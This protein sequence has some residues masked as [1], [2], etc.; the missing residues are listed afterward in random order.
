MTGQGEAVRSALKTEA[1]RRSLSTDLLVS[2][3]LAERFLHRLYLSAHAGRLTL[4][5][6]FLFA[7]WEGDLL[8]ST[9]DVDLHAAEGDFGQAARLV[10]EVAAVVP[11][12]DD[13]VRFEHGGAE[14]R[15]LSPGPQAVTRVTMSAGVGP[16][17]GRLKV[18]V[19]LGGGIRP[20][21]EIRQYP[22]LL[23]GFPSFPVRT[24]PREA[25]VAEKLAIAVEFGRDNTRLRDYWDLWFITNR[26]RFSGHVL[27][28]AA[29][30][31]FSRRDAGR[32]VT[33]RDGYWESAFDRS[34][35]AS[36]PPGAWEA[37]LRMHA[38]VS[39]PSLEEAVQSVARFSV[40]L[41]QAI[42]DGSRFDGRWSAK[43]GWQRS[44]HQNVT[45]D[46]LAESPFHAMP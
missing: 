2:R 20:G 36:R 14:A 30:S 18:D 41:L 5:G 32:F 16:A 43:H 6:A 42:R 31:A 44:P 45:E 40:P 8:R 33:R 22:S 15:I 28:D 13:G 4:K 38:P 29:A 10:A 19:G 7:A 46:P 35:A 1:R 34:F 9:V 23:P 26:Y 39:S 11:Q 3:W 25:V 37:W 21:P 12:R 17:R 27:L 24:Y